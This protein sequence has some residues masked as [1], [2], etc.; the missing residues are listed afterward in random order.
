MILAE[1]MLS[2]DLLGFCYTHKVVT[3][4]VCSHTLVH[5]FTVLPAALVTGLTGAVTLNRSR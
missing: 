1:K 5:R 4:S 2:V 3:A